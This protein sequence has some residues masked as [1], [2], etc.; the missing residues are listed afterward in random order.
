[1]EQLYY[2]LTGERPEERRLGRLCLCSG[3]GNA[4]KH[5]VV[6]LADDASGYLCPECARQTAG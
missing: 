2:E 5:E 1:M 6:A 4:A 3:C